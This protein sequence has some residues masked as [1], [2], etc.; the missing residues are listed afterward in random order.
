M[1]G[2]EDHTEGVLVEAGQ[3]VDL[4]E[5]APEPGRRCAQHLV[6]DV[7]TEPGRQQG[8]VAD[9]EQE[10][11]HRGGRP[12]GPLQRAGQLAVEDLAADQAGEQVVGQRGRVVGRGGTTGSA[13]LEVTH[14]PLH[15]PA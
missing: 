8:E 13:A 10:D 4:A 1:V 14:G 2:L 6:P 15:R 12:P 9:A 3:Q 5:A 11:G 7:A